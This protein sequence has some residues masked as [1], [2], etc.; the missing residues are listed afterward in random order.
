M[1]ISP[2]C[3]ALTAVRE[4][5]IQTHSTR[6][7]LATLPPARPDAGSGLRLVLGVPDID[8]LFARLPFVLLQ[9]ERA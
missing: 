5:R 8:D 3:S 4:S 2:F 1:S 9:D 6:S 7:T